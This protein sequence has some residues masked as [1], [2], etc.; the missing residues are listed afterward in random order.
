M[1]NDL[2]GVYFAK[3]TASGAFND[4]TTLVDGVRVLS[5]TGLYDRGEPVNIY[6]AQWVDNQTED[7]MVAHSSGTVIT[8]NVDIE[9]TFI[10]HKRYATTNIDV[11]AQHTAFINY[12][13]N[14]AVWVKSLYM[15]RSVKCVC[16]DKYEPTTIRLKRDNDNN[17]ILGTLTLHT[18]QK[19]VNAVS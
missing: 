5:V 10:V 11:A 9:I 19:P 12:F 3:N 17:Y 7:F 1:S 18:L 6:T 2:T 16:L 15:N 14:G 8:K 4:I 13:T